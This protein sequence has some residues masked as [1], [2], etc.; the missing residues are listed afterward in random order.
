MSGYRN[1]YEARC[2]RDLGPGYQ[3]EPVK[4]PYRLECSYLPDFVD[5]A[6]KRIVEAKGLFDAADR[7][8]LLAVKAQHPDYSIEIWFTN[9]ERT[10]SKLSKTRYRDWCDKHDITWKAGPRK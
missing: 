9:P 1:P 8:K 5:I 2:A 7:R 4:L 6:G 10:I 3:Y